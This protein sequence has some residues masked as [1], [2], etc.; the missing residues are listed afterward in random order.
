MA[1]PISNGRVKKAK[2]ATPNG[3]ANGDM[4]G[5]VNGHLNGHADKSKTNSSKPA[6]PRRSMT[7]RLTSIV[8]RYVFRPIFHSFRCSADVSTGC[9]LGILSSPS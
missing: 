3:Q 5:H 2:K 7:G 1:V 4:N 6:R 8:G 9:F